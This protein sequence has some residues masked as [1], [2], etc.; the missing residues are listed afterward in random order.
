MSTLGS[1]PA[2]SYPYEP[3]RRG[4]N[5][6]PLFTDALLSRSSEV[7][8]VTYPDRDGRRYM[9][10]PAEPTHYFGLFGL[11]D[12]AGASQVRGSGRLALVRRLMKLRHSYETMLPKCV[13]TDAATLCV[14]RL[15]ELSVQIGDLLA[16]IHA[17]IDSGG[18]RLRDVRL[19]ARQLLARNDRLR[20]A[21]AGLLGDDDEGVA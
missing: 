3:L 16:E 18:N 14:E 21:D 7:A 12:A 8:R 6:R 4:E 17:A 11:L 19:E 20:L 5:G 2:L 1:L 9:T 13:T 10:V 15:T